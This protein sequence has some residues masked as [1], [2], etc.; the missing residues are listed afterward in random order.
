MSEY[1]R[2]PSTGAWVLIAPEASIRPRRREALIPRT[3]E[4]DCPFCPGAEQVCGN[5]IY[6]LRTPGLLAGASWS[7]RVVANRLPLLRI[8]AR[9]FHTADG[10]RQDGLGAHEVVIETPRHDFPFVDYPLELAT[11]VIGCWRDRIRDLMNDMRMNYFVVHRSEGV[12]R[13]SHP[14]SQVLAFPVAAATLAN[15]PAVWA[16]EEYGPHPEQRRILVYQGWTAYMEYAQA[17]PFEVQ[18]ASADSRTDLLGLQDL[19]PL[20]A[21]IRDVW[22]RLALALAG[23]PVRLVLR[24]ER[25]QDSLPP[26]HR[27]RISL[28]PDLEMFLPEER[29]T[30]ICINPVPPE[31]AVQVLRSL[32]ERTSLP[33]SGYLLPLE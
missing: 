17:H 8:E 18:I 25:A 7:L 14:H 27:W 30:G 9:H 29:E 21:V 28:R 5:D 23:T 24:Y 16:R 4:T 19:R 33:D 12:T 2:N 15:R 3:P 22:R 32:P 11:E 10:D 1:R 26:A 31:E 13:Q 6:T 20:A